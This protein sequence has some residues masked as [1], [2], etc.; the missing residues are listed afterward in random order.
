M[1]PFR[2][3]VGHV[4]A[5]AE[6]QFDHE[7][8]EVYQLAI[9][10]VVLTSRILH[11]LPKGRSYLADQLRRSATSVVLNIAEGAGEFFP[12]DMQERTGLGSG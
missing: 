9:Q 8:M 2:A 6:K 10:F 12:L 1:G 11:G 7:R 5:R 3:E 4:E